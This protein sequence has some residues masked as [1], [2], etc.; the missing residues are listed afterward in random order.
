MSSS[1]VLGQYLWHE[2]LTT[3]P[4][5]GAGFYAKVLGWS[6]FPYEGDP[7]YAM[8]GNAK[9]PVGGA[10]VLGKDPLADKV[11]PNWLT[12]VGVPDLAAALATVEAKGGRVLHPV[13]AVPGNGGRYAVIADPQGAAIGLYEPG[14]SMAADSAAAPAGPDAWHELTAEDPEAALRFYKEIVGWDL[15]ATH[16]MGGEVGTYYIF[17]K[18]TTQMGGAFVRSKD[19]ASKRPRWLLYLA[20]P[21]VVAAIEAV[22]AAGG[23]VLNGPHPVPGGGWTAQI[24]DS[25]GVQVALHGPREAAAA[26]PKAPAKPKAK[27]VAKPAAVKPASPEKPKSAPKPKAKAKTKAKTKAKAK[28][29]VKTKA[30]GKKAPKAKVVTRR[31]AKV[32]VKSKPKAK[33]KPK[34]KSAAKAKRKTKTKVRAKARKAPRRGK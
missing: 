34:A 8:L 13:T 11:G 26:A 2:L 32:A 16:D 17:G 33:A 27:A 10:R 19:P 6:R 20:V 15:M 25:H 23:K 14:G 12:Y 18:G 29:K 1:A 5:A 21:G 7:G 28:N 4:D 24:A 22:K 9:G 31:K 3:D 30:K